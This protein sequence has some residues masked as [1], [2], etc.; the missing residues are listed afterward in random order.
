MNKFRF[1]I[2]VF[3]IAIFMFAFASL[4]QAQA[5][6]TWVSGVGDDVNPCSRTAPCKT[7]AGAISKT[8]AGGEI[9]CLDPGGFGAVTTTKSITLDGTDGAGFGSILA[10]STSGV[11]INGLGAV[12]T[13][14]NLSINGAGPVAGLNGVRFIQGSKLLVEGCQ[15]FNFTGGVA[16]IEIS[17]ATAASIQIKDSTIYGN[18]RGLHAT[19]TG[20]IV[21]IM[22]ED[23]SIQNNTNEG[24]KMDSNGFVTVRNSTI[25]LN[26]TGVSTTV[27]LSGANLIHCDVVA[28][29]GTGLA[30]GAS[31]NCRIGGS[32][33]IGNGTGISQSAAN[34]VK[35]FGD[36]YIADTITG[37]ALQLI[38]P[39]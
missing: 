36:N 15:I 29:A 19:S 39:Q 33:F 13:L 20:G 9:D 6:R 2:K 17:I 5:T 25:S 10:G 28:N 22:V 37:G 26:G 27:A 34:N 7:F 21:G 38:P 30:A 12:V 18:V 8:A 11:T 32:S 35:T 16:G 31:A 4:V 24:I 14:R 3:A 23:S 1:T